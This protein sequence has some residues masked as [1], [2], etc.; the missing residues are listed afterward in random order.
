MTPE[1]KYSK[2]QCIVFL[3]QTIHFYEAHYEQDIVDYEELLIKTPPTKNLATYLDVRVPKLVTTY[4]KSKMLH[5][6]ALLKLEESFHTQMSED[7]IA[8]CQELSTEMADINNILISSCD[9]TGARA[10][11]IN[12]LGTIDLDQ[13]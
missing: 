2:L 12:H 6:E 9:F 13:I 11:L 5:L 8:F 3:K 10:A 4:R 7:E 1:E